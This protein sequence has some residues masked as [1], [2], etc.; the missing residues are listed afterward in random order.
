MPHSYGKVNCIPTLYTLFSKCK[1]KEKSSTSPLLILLA[2]CQSW[3]E[4]PT[5]ETVW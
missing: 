2:L 3:P 4:H 5:L 1:K